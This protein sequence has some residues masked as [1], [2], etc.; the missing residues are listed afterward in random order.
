MVTFFVRNSL[1][2]YCHLKRGITHQLGINNI[3]H[4]GTSPVN[5]IW[6]LTFILRFLMNQLFVKLF[7][8]VKDAAIIQNFQETNTANLYIPI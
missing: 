3:R 1:E 8:I 7:V 2:M 4:V 6:N 5:L